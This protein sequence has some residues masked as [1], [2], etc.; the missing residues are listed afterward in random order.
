ME[1]KHPVALL[2]LRWDQ[3][4]PVHAAVSVVL[5]D[6]AAERTR[7]NI[8]GSLLG[9]LWWG[10]HTLYMYIL[11]NPD[12]RK[13]ARKENVTLVLALSSGS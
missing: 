10:T 1:A 5:Q 11:Q 7:H 2:D 12:S 9:L 6:E 8:W 4:R 3:M 13:D